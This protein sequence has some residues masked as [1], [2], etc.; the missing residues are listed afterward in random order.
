MSEA[1]R[2]DDAQG[3]YN[4][5]T[6]AAF[7]SQARLIALQIRSLEHRTHSV[8]VPRN[9]SV[10]HLKN[11]IQAVFDV[12][13]G[14]Q[15]LIFQGRVLKD[16][17]HLT[18]YANLDDGKVLH[19]VVRPPDAP[20]NPM[21]DEPR[22]Q[23]PRR[24]YG[25]ASR[26]FPAFSSRIPMMEGYAL[27][28]LDTTMGD[29][30]DSNSL[31]SS[32]LN[33][34]S[35]LSNGGRSGRTSTLNVTPEAN[36]RRTSQAQTAPGA[37]SSVT[38]SPLEFNFGHRSF[39]DLPLPPSLASTTTSDIRSSMGLPFPVHISSISTSSASSAE[40]MQEIRARLRGDG[41]SQ[42]AQVG[43]VLNEL[44][45]LME[46]AS[47]RLREVANALQDDTPYTDE[48]RNLRL[49]RRVLRTARVVQ[50]MSLI[51]HF[52]GSVLASADIDRRTRPAQT[53]TSSEN[54]PR[55]TPQSRTA[56]K[57]STNTTSDDNKTHSEEKADDTSAPGTSSGKRKATHD[58]SQSSKKQKGKGKEKTD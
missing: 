18:D 38:G 1:R 35:G 13:S 21:N 5:S 3:S 28:T 36:G 8:T 16:D 40:Q 26:A 23:I 20:Q 48:Q 25:R 42:T 53:D 51:H 12:E 54:N 14:R 24:T 46:S 55:R 17:K 41:N 43:L 9:S 52:L 32:V 30:G 44:A 57:A 15:R 10:L 27:I 19:L 29:L 58:G 7:D 6:N 37:T 39:A 33:G 11:E 2:N 34:I 4:A 49:Y 31:F 56:E 50:G 45:D 47:P 22:T